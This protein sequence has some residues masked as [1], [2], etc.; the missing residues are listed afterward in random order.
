MDINNLY[1]V[2][3]ITKSKGLKGELKISF[4]TFFLA[5]LEEIEGK[6]EHLFVKT[7]N[8]CVPYFL[9]KISAQSNY[10]I[11]KFEE[12]D[13]K[14]VAEKLRNARLLI[15]TEKINDFLEEEEN[16]FWNFLLGFTLMND[17]VEI[18]KI[19]DI[20]YLDT[21]E[22]A[23]LHYENRELLVPLHE[24]LIEII[25]EENEIIAMALPDGLLDL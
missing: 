5:Y 18:G 8:D 24:N 2:G 25:D 11:I 15:E 3:V 9:E 20:Y 13:T 16:T 23:M 14:N 4:E 22:I 19:E 21:H 17:D 6:L 12:V 10:H 7:K 1:Q